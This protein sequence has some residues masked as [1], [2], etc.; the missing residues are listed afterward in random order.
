MF[1]PAP[2]V[3]EQSAPA[4]TGHPLPRHVHARHAAV[5]RHCCHRHRRRT[6]DRPDSLRRRCRSD[7][8]VQWRLQR[9]LTHLPDAETMMALHVLPAVLVV[10]NAV[11]HSASVLL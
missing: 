9:C 5:Q 7:R 11:S 6:H 10:D 4:L 8:A 2:F 3:L 1:T